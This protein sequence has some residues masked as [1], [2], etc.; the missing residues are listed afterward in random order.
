MTRRVIRALRTGARKPLRFETTVVRPDV[1]RS[2]IGAVIVIN[3]GARTGSA[4]TTA[5][6]PWRTFGV[7]TGPVGLPDAARP[8]LDRRQVARTPGGTRRPRRGRAA[9]SRSRP[10]PATRSAR[11]GWA[12][13][14]PA[15]A[16][17]ARRT[18]LRSATR[19]SH[20]CIRMRIPEAEW[21]FDHVG[22]RD[23]GASSSD[24]RP[25]PARGRGRRSRLLGLLVWD[26]AHD[27]R[28]RGR[29]LG[30]RG[31]GRRGAEAARCRALDRDGK[32]D[33]RVAAREGRR[34]QLLG[35]VVPRV[36]GGGAAR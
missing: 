32:F 14:R 15:S 36:Q 31:Q 4:S 28:Q 17:T 3:R 24:A 26:V 20:G 10:A 34:R 30:R 9:S 1:T 12:S 22:D 2:S 5:R 7:A 8:L 29:G 35:V 18:P 27:E 23:A 21:L 16:S 11:A 6:N 19:A 25:A 13:R 33:A